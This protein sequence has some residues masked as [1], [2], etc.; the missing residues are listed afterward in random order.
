MGA[1]CDL[2]AAIALKFIQ[3][4]LARA[5]LQQKAKLELVLAIERV[6]NEAARRALEWKADAASRSDGGAGLRAEPTEIPCIIAEGRATCVL[7]DR[8]D[9]QAVVRELKA[10]CLANGQTPKECQTD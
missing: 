1:L 8:G 10:A 6:G 3:A 7:V 5:D 4:W 9:W 2:I